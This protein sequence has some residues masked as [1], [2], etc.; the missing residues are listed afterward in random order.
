[1]KIDDSGPLDFIFDSGDGITVIDEEIAEDLELVKHKVVLNEGTVYGALI[2]HN[3]IEVGGFLIE[4]NI[5][6]YST[7]LDHLE[8]SLGRNIDGILGYDLLM[9]HSIRIDYDTHNFEI[10]DH[11]AHPKKGDPVPFKLVNPHY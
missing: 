10:Y 3:T 6:V 5:K 4:K 1:M 11:G 9:H 8:I 2:K 7:D